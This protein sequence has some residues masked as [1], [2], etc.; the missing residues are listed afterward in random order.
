MTCRLAGPKARDFSWMNK[1]THTGRTT[2]REVTAPYC[3]EGANFT[4]A[5]ATNGCYM[6]AIPLREGES[7]PFELI[8]SELSV[9]FL[10]GSAPPKATVAPSDLIS[11]IHCGKCGS[12]M[13]LFECKDCRGMSRVTCERCDGKRE[14][15]CSCKCGHEHMA[16]CPDCED[17]FVPCF[18]CGGKGRVRCTCHVDTDVV[19]I[20]EKVGVDR[21]YVRAA[22]S[23]LPFALNEPIL[24]SWNHEIVRLE[25]ENWRVG[26]APC[27]N[28]A[29]SKDKLVLKNADILDA[30]ASL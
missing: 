25:T 14:I 19:V 23:E 21:R 30:L 5:V 28:P 16:A 1:H 18:P 15:S 13:T 27:G 29:P 2:P 10:E 11:W 20:A 7:R 3:V 24:V 26:I 17:G 6:I 12:L 9:R 8:D 22:L 4:Y